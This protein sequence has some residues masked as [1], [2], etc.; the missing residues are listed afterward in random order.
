MTFTES[1]RIAFAAAALSN[2]VPLIPLS[3]NLA[4]GGDPKYEELPR[5]WPQ[6]FC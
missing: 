5:V 3:T 1:I 6:H 2:V 4:Q